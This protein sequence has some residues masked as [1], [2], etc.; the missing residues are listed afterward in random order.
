MKEYSYRAGGN[1]FKLKE[2]RFT[3]DI[4]KKSF[5]VR[6]VRLQNRLPR[7]VVSARLWKCLRSD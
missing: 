4:M 1:S 6:V 5:C 7:E 3:L 2:S